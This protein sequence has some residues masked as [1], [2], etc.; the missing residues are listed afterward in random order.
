MLRSHTESQEQYLSMLKDGIREHLTKEVLSIASYVEELQS[1]IT[2]LKEQIN[3]L[4]T[5][6]NYYKKRLKLIGQ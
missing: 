2:A 1:T 4:Q 6:L 5:H 3:V